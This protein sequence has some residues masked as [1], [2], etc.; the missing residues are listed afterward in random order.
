MLRIYL[1]RHGET[2]W[3][4]EDRL[5]GS[6]DV[7][8]NA[9]GLAQAAELAERLAGTAFDH[10]YTSSMRRSRD[11]AA[12]L[13]GQSPSTALPELDELSLGFFE[14]RSA[15]EPGI[16]CD[17][18]QRLADPTDSLDGGESTDEH[19]AR[20]ATAA[21]RIREAHPSGTVL[22]IAHGGT[23]RQLLR[24]WLGISAEEAS[25]HHQDHVELVVIE[26]ADDG[27]YLMPFVP[28]SRDGSVS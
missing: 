10:I 7:P 13:V 14:G 26:I 4:A 9:T 17:L 16:V 23:N 12:P 24:A 21:Q 6:T 2:D 15:D 5:Q 19:Y 1:T 27:A 28:A 22:V 20:V 3:N 18:R 8:L 11:T 25:N